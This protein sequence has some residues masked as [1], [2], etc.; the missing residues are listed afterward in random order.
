MQLILD[1][2]PGLVGRKLKYTHISK[3]ETS[4][5]LKRSLKQLELARV[6]HPVFH[7]SG[8]GIPLRA[9]KKE[10]DYKLLFLDI[11]LLMRSL[12][13]NVLDLQREDSMFANKGAL[14]EQFIGQQWLCIQDSS[15]NPELYYW[16]REKTGTSAAVDFLFQIA[17]NIVPA[18]VKGGTTGSLKSLHVFAA[19]KKSPM[20]LRYNLDR[21][22]I[23]Q[24]T[25][26]I[27]VKACHTFK[28]FSLPLYPVSETTRL[29]GA[30]S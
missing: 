21:P 19:L 14:A 17:G 13:M 3:D 28:F 4:T 27:P 22:G 18:E 8:N 15:D 10:R 25:S 6:L 11:G 5:N 16:N 30:V 7:S 12:G 9:E 2:V 26:R 29:L 20:A 1:K 24:V 23:A